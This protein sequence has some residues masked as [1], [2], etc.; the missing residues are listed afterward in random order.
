MTLIDAVENLNYIIL[1]VNYPNQTILS[2]LTDLDVKKGA[3]LTV[4]RK[5]STNACAL[6]LINSRLIAISNEICK[7]I[8]IEKVKDDGKR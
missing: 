1:S 3:K 7:T 8:N 2:R 4:I 6:I 5:S